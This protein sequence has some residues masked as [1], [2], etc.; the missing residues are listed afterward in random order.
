MVP[1]IFGN[2]HIMS[3]I[4]FKQK[5]R[6]LIPELAAESSYLQFLREAYNLQLIQKYTTENKENFYELCRPQKK[7]DSSEEIPSLFWAGAVN[8]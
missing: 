3:S 7:R 2:E 4:E 5:V 1:K 8:P 6:R